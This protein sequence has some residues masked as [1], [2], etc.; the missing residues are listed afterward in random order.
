M[1]NSHMIK[2]FIIT[3][4]SIIFDSHKILNFIQQKKSNI[5]EKYNQRT[6]SIV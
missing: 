6:L 5:Q 2:S 3:N 4:Q 1:K